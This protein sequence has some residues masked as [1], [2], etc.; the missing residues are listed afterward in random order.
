MNYRL[1][2]VVVITLF[3]IL[4]LT[5][6]NVSYAYDP[7]DNAFPEI[8]EIFKNNSN[9]FLTEYRS[10]YYLDMK[11]MGIAE[12]V[13]NPE[14]FLNEVANLLFSMQ[15]NFTTGLIT[16][17][18]YCYEIDLYTIFS[19]MIEAV[20]AEM[21]IAVFDELSSLA[22][23][24]LGIY[25]LIKTI[26]DQR[27]QVW[28]AILQTIAILTLALALFHNPTAMLK[29]VDDFSKDMSRSVLA[30]TYRATNQGDSPESVV[31]AVSN[32]LWMMFV[33]KPWQMLE[34][35]SIE[36]AEMEQHR[37]LS[38]PPKSKERQAIINELEKSD[39]FFTP[40]W[41]VSRLAFILMYI[42]PMIIMG[43]II[44]LLALLI[45]GY[46]FLTIFFSLGGAFVFI[47]ALIPFF[48]P[49]IINNWAAKI[50]A[51][52]FIKALISFVLAIVFAVNAALFNLIGVYGWFVVLMLQ[53]LL[54]GIVVWKRKDFTD[55]FTNTRR[56]MQGSIKPSRKD[57]NL[58]GRLRMENSKLSFRRR[59][60]KYQENDEFEEVEI[61]SETRTYRRVNT[62][63]STEEQKEVAVA[64]PTD[65]HGNEAQPN[66]IEVKLA[67]ESEIT[68]M[69]D[70]LKALTR[71]AEE[72]L[73]RKYEEETRAAEEHGESLGKEPEYNSF[74]KRVRTREQL[75]AP[76]FDNREITAV[77]KSIQAIQQAGGSVEDVY[78]RMAAKDTEEAERP[79]NLESIK[80]EV[81]GDNVDLDKQEA[82]SIIERQQS[83]D[84]A[85]EFNQRYNK[86]YDMAFFEELFKKYGVENVRHMLDRM[87]EVEERD[88][89]MIHNPAG[90]LTTGLKNNRRDRVGVDSHS[91]R[92]EER[93]QIPQRESM[94]RNMKNAAGD[95]N[96]KVK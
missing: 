71:K 32:D 89:T 56:A 92:Q 49:R 66:D 52:G 78:E 95:K 44:G 12:T 14:G 16:I 65:L 43:L 2:R 50:I 31:I 64:K 94:R 82:Y 34:F 21:K 59:G 57:F 48:G 39:N 80:M 83:S 22:I 33:H 87:K 27:T 5:A 77:A 46:Q 8:E 91:Q 9:P 18:Y 26:T 17:V 30:G 42:I 35:G 79:K 62:P 69:N 38:L 90:Y 24:L 53:I 93:Q 73:Q 51:N 84:Y 25:Y 11:D 15:K 13:K 20:F 4:L 61:P 41:G 28:I 47:L 74:V 70:S 10:N 86:Q 40:N 37:I 3:A 54:M 88:G 1:K 81:S 72:L 36:I 29:G 7:A 63:R 75:G 23:V 67:N 76:R 96:E 19:S 45:L 55:L 60:A 85:E 58:E 6:F 68:H